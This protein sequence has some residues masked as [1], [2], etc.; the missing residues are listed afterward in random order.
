MRY[1]THIHIHTN[2]SEKM[3]GINELMADI[4]Y[5]AVLPTLLKEPASLK[6]FLLCLK[7]ESDALIVFLCRL[8]A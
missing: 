6:M 2:F 3:S 4:S 1:C 8:R 7:V 5:P